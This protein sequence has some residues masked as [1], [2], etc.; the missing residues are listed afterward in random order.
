VLSLTTAPYPTHPV[1]K[2]RRRGR[3][4]ER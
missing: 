3:E 1:M 2:R 4:E